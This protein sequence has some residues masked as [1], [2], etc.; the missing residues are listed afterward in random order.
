MVQHAYALLLYLLCIR[1]RNV[2]SAPVSGSEVTETPIVESRDV[3]RVHYLKS[4][5][6]DG[7]GSNTVVYR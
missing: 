5:I 1:T 6:R 4:V 3:L 7:G 2:T